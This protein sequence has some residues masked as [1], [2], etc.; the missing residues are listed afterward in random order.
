M[1]QT[2]SIQ[3]YIGGKMD[4]AANEFRIAFLEENSNRD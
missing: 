2:K 3:K 4:G 1:A